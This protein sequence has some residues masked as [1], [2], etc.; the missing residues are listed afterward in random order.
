MSKCLLWYLWLFLR[1]LGCVGSCRRPAGRIPDI[2]CR[3]PGS[4]CRVMTKYLKTYVSY[5]FKLFVNCLATLFKSTSKPCCVTSRLSRGWNIHSCCLC[6]DNTLLHTRNANNIQTTL[7][8]AHT[9]YLIF[10]LTLTQNTHHRKSCQ[11]ILN[12]MKCCAM[13]AFDIC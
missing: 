9:I 11:I 10:Q 5:A 12:V 7:T 1:S 3:N 6:M 13:L 8:D 2:F 4:W